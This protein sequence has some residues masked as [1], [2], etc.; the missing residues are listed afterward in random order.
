[1][2]VIIKRGCVGDNGVTLNASETPVEVSLN[3]ALHMIGAGQAV[4]AEESDAEPTL[5][6]TPEA[7]PPEDKPE[8]TTPARKKAKK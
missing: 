5:R 7:A 6:M 2:K 3:V 1:M 8:P 4:A